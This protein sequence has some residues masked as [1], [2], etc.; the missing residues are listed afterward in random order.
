[1]ADRFHVSLTFDVDTVSLWMSRQDR[2][3]CSR[4]EFGVV[5]ARR[6]LKLLASRSIHATF[7]VPGLTAS[8]YPDL[9]K[10][11]VDGGHEIGHH[12]WTHVPPTI[13]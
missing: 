3:A 11:I 6:I 8:T 10:E 9:L 7:F 13:T 5:G 12:G 1:M 2:T 4:G